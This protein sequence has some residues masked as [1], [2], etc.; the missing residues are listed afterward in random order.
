MNTPRT[1][2]MGFL[3][4]LERVLRR[5]GD[6][7]PETAEDVRLAEQRIPQKRFLGQVPSMPVPHARAKD[8]RIAQHW[9]QRS[10]IALGATDPVEEIK[11]RAQST[12]LDAIE[13]G[14]QGPP[15]DPSQ[16]AEMLGIQLKPNPDV[17]DARTSARSGRFVIEFNPLRPPARLR[18]SLA[19][20]IVH[21]LFPDCAE[22]V[23]HRATHEDMSGDEWQLEMLC[24]VGAAEI[25]M[26]LGV[27]P[28]DAQLLPN[29]ETI[30]D[31]R[32]RFMV[33]A[34]AVLL[35]LMRLT[36]HRS[37]AFAAHRDDSGRYQIDY[38]IASASLGNVLIPTSGAN[39]TKSSK[40][41]ECIAIGFTDKETDVRFG[42]ESWDIDYLGVAP[43]PGQLI[44]RVLGIAR[45]KTE[46]RITSRFSIVRG[47][48]TKPR[49]KDLKLICQIVNDKALTWGAGFALA[50]RKEWPTA[51]RDF[52]NWATLNRTEFRLGNVHF[53]QVRHDLV[54]ASLVTQHGYGPSQKPRIRYFALDQALE[55]V[56]TFARE[57]GASIHLPR[58]GSGQAGGDWGI[59]REIID[60]RLSAAQLSVTVYDLPNAEIPRAK[61]SSL[62]EVTAEQDQFV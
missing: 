10:V 26:P 40:A 5:R 49:G 47:D 31:L 54:L 59:V 58:I 24:N 1:N 15:Y 30:L 42:R 7:V 62:F 13:K 35:R 20:E 17:F 33:S 48:A 6:L 52:T 46:S 19:H 56:A 39:L 43:Y 3:N 36:P 41:S 53:S 22:E 29:V 28:T 34:E 37:F 25:L 21:T 12:V 38:S 51:Q 9:T 60:Q 57:N 14:W 2:R 27:F 8:V 50:V 4:D 16:L 18:F 45:P 61:Q 55:K 32:R 11:T 44:P 23:R